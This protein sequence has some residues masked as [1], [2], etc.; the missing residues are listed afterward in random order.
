MTFIPIFTFFLELCFAFFYL[1]VK[2]L[3][4]NLSAT[5]KTNCPKFSQ[6]LTTMS[7]S[8]SFLPDFVV[9]YTSLFLDNDHTYANGITTGITN[10]ETCD[11]AMVSSIRSSKWFSSSIMSTFQYM[12]HST[13]FFLLIGTGC[14]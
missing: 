1:I 9:L 14:T 10:V 7:D 8:L 3:L 2:F 12:H 5:K 4:S 6:N 13:M 11:L